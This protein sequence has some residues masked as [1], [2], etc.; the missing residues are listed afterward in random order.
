MTTKQERRSGTK[1]RDAMT[2]MEKISG[3]PLTIA[4]ILKSLRECDTISQ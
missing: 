2:F 1:K 4:E 3:G